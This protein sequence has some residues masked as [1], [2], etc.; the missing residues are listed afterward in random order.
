M[1]FTPNE[2]QYLRTQR[3]GRIATVGQDGT[4]HVV[5]VGFRFNAERE[6]IEVGGTGLGKSKKFRDARDRPRVAFVVDDVASPDPFTPRGIE[7][8]GRAEV[9]EEGGKERFGEGW[10][11]AWIRIVPE[12][13]V[14]WGIDGS[15]FA[16]ANARSVG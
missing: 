15:A 1:R 9:F 7:V 6:E 10:D 2:T 3:L 5:P 4:P 8:R 14:G 11:P 12:R 16:G 13:I